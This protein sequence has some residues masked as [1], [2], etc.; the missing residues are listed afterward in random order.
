[1]RAPRDHTPMKTRRLPLL[2]LSIAL[3]ATVL[4]APAGAHH[5]F[6]MFD[7][8]KSVTVKG[9]VAEFQWTNPHVVLYVNADAGDGKPAQPW[10]LEL[11]SPGNLTRGGWTRHAFKAGDKVEVELSPLRDGNAGGAFRKATV[12]DTGKVWTS[13]LRATEKP[14]LE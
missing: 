14:G 10:A 5:S 9:T 4:A 1:M 12:L 11:T 6:A 8:D 13:N 2:P 3:A 7:F